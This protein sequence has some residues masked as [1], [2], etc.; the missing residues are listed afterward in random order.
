MTTYDY[1]NY[2]RYSRIEIKLTNPASPF[3][4]LIPIKA[5][6]GK[7]QTYFYLGYTTKDPATGIVR[8]ASMS[9][10]KVVTHAGSASVAGTFGP[11]V[12]SSTLGQL[13][14]SM[15][16]KAQYAGSVSINSG[17][18]LGGAFLYFSEYDY[19]GSGAVQGWT[20]GPPCYVLNYLLYSTNYD[21]YLTGATFSYK[22]KDMKGVVCFT[23]SGN[24]ISGATLTI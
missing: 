13:L 21:L 4:I 18:N 19:F 16:L 1:L 24:S 3:D 22:Y 5:D 14:S 12:E 15:N 11:A 9:P 10:R 8:I 20:N 6:Q 23:D 7:V 2:H 17:D